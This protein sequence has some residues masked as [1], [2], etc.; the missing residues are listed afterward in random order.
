MNINIFILIMGYINMFIDIKIKC[1]KFIVD[2][3]I[4]D[5]YSDGNGL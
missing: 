3:K 4:L 5:K 2:K 1:L